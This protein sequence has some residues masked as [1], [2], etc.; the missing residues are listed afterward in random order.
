M[1]GFPGLSNKNDQFRDKQA[2]MKQQHQKDFQKH[3]QNNQ[4]VD[5]RKQ[6]IQRQ[7]QPTQE[8]GSH[9]QS[10]INKSQKNSQMADDV[11]NE[12]LGSRPKGTFVTQH[13]VPGKIY[14]LISR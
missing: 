9:H 12:I 4:N 10:Q 8:S 3:M 5:A 1:I 14:K 7:R 6:K 13:N 2:L 11:F